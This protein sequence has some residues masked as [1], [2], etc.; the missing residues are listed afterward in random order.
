MAELVVLPEP[1]RPAISTTVG[2]FGGELDREGLATERT[3]EFVVD[4]LDD[5]LAGIE[6]LRTG[7]AD[8]VLADAV[9]H[10][11]HDG[12]VHVGFEERRADLLHD[13][14]DVGLGETALAADLLDDAFESAGEIVEHTAPRLP[15]DP[16]PSRETPPHPGGP[17]TPRAAMRR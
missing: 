12:D 3:G 2:G 11:T 7:G 17:A 5:L 13:L 16:H 14:V 9:A 10:R 1:C 6:R 4:R 8:R 15:A